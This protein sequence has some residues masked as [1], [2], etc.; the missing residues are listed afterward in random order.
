MKGC[1]EDGDKINLIEVENKNILSDKVRYEI[2]RESYVSVQLTWSKGSYIF[3]NREDKELLDFCLDFTRVKNK[4]A[5]L[6]K[7]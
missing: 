1:E 7:C 2:V 3:L 6:S 4:G 5:Y